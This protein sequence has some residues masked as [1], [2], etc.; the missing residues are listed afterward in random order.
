MSIDSQKAERTQVSI[1]G[2]K[3]K[4]KCL[5]SFQWNIVQPSKGTKYQYLLQCGWT[6]E[7][8]CLVKEA[9]YKMSSSLWFHL[10]DILCG[11]GKHTETEN[12]SMVAR[13]WRERGLGSAFLID[14]RFPFRMTQTFWNSVESMVAQCYEY[15]KWHW[16]IHVQMLFEF[17]FIEKRSNTKMYSIEKRRNVVWH[18]LFW[19][20]SV[21]VSVTECEPWTPW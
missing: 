3:A 1:N 9:R 8:L 17:T 15:T 12:R 5:I 7:T 16:S 6:L 14:I 11:R 10:Y 4:T 2:R 21:R 19:N 13:I 20:L 18:L